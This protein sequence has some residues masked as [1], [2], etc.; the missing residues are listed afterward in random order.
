MLDAPVTSVPLPPPQ[1]ASSPQRVQLWYARLSPQDRG[2]YL[3]H[4]DQL[5]DRMPPRRRRLFDLLVRRL[6]DR[7]ELPFHAG[8]GNWGAAVGALSSAVLGVGVSLWQGKEQESL[9]KDLA[10]DQSDLQKELAKIQ[11][12]SQLEA[13]RLLMDAQTEAAKLAAGAQLESTRI[14][15]GGE[16]E[17]TRM[18]TAF[19]DAHGTTLIIGGTAVVGGVAALL[20]VI[21]N[22]RNRRGKRRRSRR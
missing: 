2:R 10:R 14:L 19:W 12:E 9:Q 6:Q 11:Q 22:R 17:K 7:V 1:I 3:D 5:I 8:L 15:T 18:Q 13:S 16:V 21:N 4:L 20:L